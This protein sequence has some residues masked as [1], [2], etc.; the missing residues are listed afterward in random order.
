MKKLHIK[1]RC[2]WVSDHPLYI[3]YHD[4][5]WGVPL[6][7][8][9][10]LFE[11]LILEGMQA[12]LNWLTILK[13]RENYRT[14]FDN[15]DAAKIAQ[16]DAHKI[17]ELLNNSGIVRN[18]LKIHATIANAKAFLQVRSEWKN[19]STYIWHFTDGKPVQ[20]HWRSA[21]QVPTT[22]PISDKLSMD[23]KQRGF[24]FVGSTICYAF[25]QAVGMVNDHTTNCFRHA[26]LG[27]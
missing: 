6:Y 25:M 2:A 17:K 5:E 19:F 1:N 9:H 11:F 27:K 8:E 14:C 13:K 15:F 10:A 21:K 3:D 22:T 12:G 18:K 23:L 26:E 4:S 7:D 16:Y 20:N 24:K